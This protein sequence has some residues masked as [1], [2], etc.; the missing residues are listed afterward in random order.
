MCIAF[1]Q[2]DQFHDETTLLSKC[3]Q[4]ICGNAVRDHLGIAERDPSTIFL[5][6]FLPRPFNLPPG[7]VF[8]SRSTNLIII[9]RDPEGGILAAGVYQLP[10]EEWRNRSHYRSRKVPRRYA[11][12]FV[13]VDRKITTRSG[14]GKGP[15]VQQVIGPFPARWQPL[16]TTARNLH[17]NVKIRLILFR[18]W[19]VFAWPVTR[20][21]VRVRCPAFRLFESRFIR[22]SVFLFW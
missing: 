16:A 19:I 18:E 14:R 6:S 15:G 3:R 7:F 4:F 20:R 5:I 17:S 8:E 12:S 13:N 1:Y 21:G 10:D 2:S 11:R 9:T 22:C